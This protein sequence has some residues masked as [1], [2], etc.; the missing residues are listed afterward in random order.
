MSNIAFLFLPLAFSSRCPTFRVSL[1]SSIIY[2][3]LNHV[4]PCKNPSNPSVFWGDL[5]GSTRLAGRAAEPGG[6][7]K[8]LEGLR[9]GEAPGAADEA[10]T[11]H[12]RHTGWASRTGTT[13]ATGSR[14]HEL[15]T[16]GRWMCIG[17]NTFALPK[18]P[19]SLGPVNQS[20][21]WWPFKD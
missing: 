8:C 1:L 3:S 13:G 16:V 7:S 21:D 6:R 4:K 11:S 9:P 2:I 17:Q 19:V 20:Q 12:A 10:R 18:K 15:D 14:R 5:Q